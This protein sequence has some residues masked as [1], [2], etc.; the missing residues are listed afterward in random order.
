MDKAYNSV[1][2]TGFFNAT[3]NKTAKIKVLLNN[4]PQQF[5]YPCTKYWMIMKAST[6]ISLSHDPARFSYKIFLLSVKNS[7]KF[8]D[9]PTSAPT[10]RNHHHLSPKTKT[11]PEKV[12]TGKIDTDET[13][14]MASMKETRAFCVASHQIFYGSRL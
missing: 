5:G 13:C 10:S 8:Y 1:H 11:Q 7:N 12:L 9:V 2:D 4:A 6:R 14:A 3:H